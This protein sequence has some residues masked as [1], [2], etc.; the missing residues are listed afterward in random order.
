M[1]WDDVFALFLASERVCVG[2]GVHGALVIH[3]STYYYCM[4]T[5]SVTHSFLFFLSH[6]SNTR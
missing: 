6:V 4:H 5:L 3:L 1:V 2:G